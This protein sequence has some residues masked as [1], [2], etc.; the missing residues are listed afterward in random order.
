MLFCFLVVITKKSARE[1]SNPQYMFFSVYVLID[2]CARYFGKFP[3]LEISK[4]SLFPFP[5]LLFSLSNNNK[6]VEKNNNNKICAT[7]SIRSKRNQVVS[8]SESCICFPFLYISFGFNP[9]NNFNLY[10]SEISIRHK[11][12]KC[13][14]E[15]F[16]SIINK[17][18]FQT[19]FFR[20]SNLFAVAH[21][22]LRT[23]R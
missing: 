1:M 13:M 18:K 9:Y 5:H 2:Y 20:L 11:I 4:T 23:S 19:R 8:K 14:Y 22:K 10:V 3:N 6:D 21:W 17:L 7:N 16:Q 15:K 12:K